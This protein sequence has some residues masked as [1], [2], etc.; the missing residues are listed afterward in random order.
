M[1]SCPDNNFANPSTETKR[2]A[3]GIISYTLFFSALFIIAALIMVLITSISSKPH[4]GPDKI[5][6]LIFW[7]VIFRMFLSIILGMC[8]L[9]RGCYNEPHS[10]QVIFLHPITNRNR[11]YSETPLQCKLCGLQP[12]V[13]MGIEFVV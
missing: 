13:N 6:G 3:R 5:H 7:S 8:Y 11:E 4:E 12:V 9:G 1:M 10:F 2:G